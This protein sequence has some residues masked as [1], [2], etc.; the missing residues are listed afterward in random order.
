MFPGRSRFRRPH[1][2]GRPRPPRLRDR[3]TFEVL[4]PAGSATAETN[5]VQALTAYQKAIAAYALA[6]GTTLERNHIRLE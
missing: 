4:H 3:D 5:E 1:A 6:T 2:G